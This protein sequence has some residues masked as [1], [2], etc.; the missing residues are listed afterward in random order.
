[1]AGASNSTKS[2]TTVNPALLLKHQDQH[3]SVSYRDVRAS[4]VVNQNC[5][6]IS[7][8]PVSESKVQTVCTDEPEP[9]SLS[10]VNPEICSAPLTQVLESQCQQSVNLDPKVPDSEDY[11]AISAQVSEV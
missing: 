7:I 1:M 6:D 2:Q 11:S 8:P 3:Q 4:D 9:H 5:S 10:Q